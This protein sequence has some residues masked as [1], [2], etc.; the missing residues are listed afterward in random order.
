[1]IKIRSYKIT[2]LNQKF[3]KLKKVNF[4]L[5]SKFNNLFECCL[6]I[7]RLKVKIV[8]LIKYFINLK[9]F[10]FVMISLSNKVFVRD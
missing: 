10:N 3:Q 4:L 7:L 1:M 8:S 5:N 9:N 2:I 6:N